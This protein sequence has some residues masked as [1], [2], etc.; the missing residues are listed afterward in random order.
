MTLSL[1]ALSSMK[2]VTPGHV[3]LIEDSDR[4]VGEV[5]I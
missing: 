1:L 3:G 5:D 2:R 4:R